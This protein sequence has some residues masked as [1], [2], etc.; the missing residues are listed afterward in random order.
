MS[1]RF[2]AILSAAVVLALASPLSAEILTKKFDWAPVNGIQRVDMQSN[3]MAISE[4]RF[5]LG[6]TIAPVRVS[7]AK[8]I[9]RVDNNSQIDQEVGIAIA[10]FD[11]DGNLIA[12][13]DGGNKVGELNKGDRSEF[14]A[15]FAYVYRNLKNARSFLLTLETLPKGAGKSRKWKP[16]PTP[17]S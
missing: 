5:D 4:V 3:D 10:V 14:T 15:R 16:R 1:R 13:G 11:G 17:V 2:P 9:V 7:S 8:A 6:D 12:A